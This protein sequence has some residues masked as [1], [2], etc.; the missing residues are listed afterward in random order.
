MPPTAVTQP[1]TGASALFL[2]TAV[3][4]ALAGM[5]LG[6]AMGAS[7]DH[8]LQTVHVHMNLVGWASMFL[9]GLFYRLVPAADGVLAR[10]HYAIAAL[11]LLIFA[12]GL[13]GIMLGK[14]WGE[15]GAIVGSLL[16]ILSMALFAGIVFR[17]TRAA[18]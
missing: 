8:T 15:A 7:H 13:T 3:V 1:R 5:A 9:F 10:W 4:V 18:A 6:I 17:A 14:A 16:T 12:G 2:R 11:G